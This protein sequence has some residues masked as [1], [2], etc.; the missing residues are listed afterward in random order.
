M[1]STFVYR[2]YFDNPDSLD[3][4]WL[5]LG[6]GTSN[7]RATGRSGFCLAVSLTT[8]PAFA[9]YCS[10][11]VIDRLDWTGKTRMMDDELPAPAP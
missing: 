4:F 3:G 5:N 6:G 10:L 7:P 2:I 11:Q 1:P 8:L 9:N